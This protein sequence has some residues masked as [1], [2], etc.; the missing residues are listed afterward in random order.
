[1]SPLT[2]SQAQVPDSIR[3]IR[4]SRLDRLI[5]WT[6]NFG[7]LECLRYQRSSHIPAN[8]FRTATSQYGNA[9]SHPGARLFEPERS[10][11]NASM[12][13]SS[14]RNHRCMHTSC[15]SRTSPIK[16]QLPCHLFLGRR[17]DVSRIRCS[18]VKLGTV[19]V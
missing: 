16:P 8:T 12:E 6:L 17:F 4:R 18:L 9:N 7:A 13:Q 3:D 1:M 2:S 11:A 14:P 15:V 10:T 5:I 19:S